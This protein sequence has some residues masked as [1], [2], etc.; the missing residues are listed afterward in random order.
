MTTSFK[1]TISGAALVA[2]REVYACVGLF[3]LVFSLLSLLLRWADSVIQFLPSYPQHR[4]NHGIA[5]SHYANFLALI[6]GFAAAVVRPLMDLD[7]ISRI[8][9]D[10]AVFIWFLA[11]L[12]VGV[13]VLLLSRQFVGTCG[14]YMR[15]KHIQAFRLSAMSVL[16]MPRIVGLALRDIEIPL[17]WWIDQGFILVFMLL[18]VWP[19]TLAKYNQPPW[20]ESRQG[21]MVVASCSKV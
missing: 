18:A 17:L 3:W 15:Q 6:L 9:L 19:K 12:R 4:A 16:I 13:L 14:W 7:I 1:S 20:R 8:L 21:T 5:I 10:V 2:T 11:A